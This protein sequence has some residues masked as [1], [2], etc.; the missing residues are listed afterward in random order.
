MDDARGIDTT[1]MWSVLNPSEIPFDCPPPPSIQAQPTVTKRMD[2]NLTFAAN[3][4]NL[5]G[6]KVPTSRGVILWLPARGINSVWRMGVVPVGTVS[7]DQLQYQIAT[8]TS[9]DTGFG[10]RLIPYYDASPTTPSDSLCFLTYVGELAIPYSHDGSNLA[11]PTG[12]NHKQFLVSPDFATTF[13]KARVIAGTLSIVS[14]TWVAS[15]VLAGGKVPLVGRLHAT[16]VLDVRSVMQTTDHATGQIVAFSSTA[17][18]DNS[19]PK[20]D[21]CTEVAVG[22]GVQFLVGPD[23]SPMLMPP[24]SD[25]CVHHNGHRHMLNV[26]SGFYD[27]STTPEDISTTPPGNFDGKH[28]M[29]SNHWVSPWSVTADTGIGTRAGFKGPTVNV[30]PPSF[31]NPAGSYDIEVLMN[32]GRFQ[33]STGPVEPGSSVGSIM[34]YGQ[35]VHVFAALAKDGSIQY[36]SYQ[37]VVISM[38][39]AGGGSDW[40]YDTLTFLFSAA[41]YQRGLVTNNMPRDLHLTTNPT[42]DFQTR[43]TSAMYIGSQIITGLQVFVFASTVSPGPLYLPKVYEFTMSVV[44][45]TQ[46]NMGELGPARIATYDGLGV[47]QAVT[48]NGVVHVQGVPFGNVAKFMDI[49]TYSRA[50]LCPGTVVQLGRLFD[51]PHTPF[52]RTWMRKDY[53]Q[54]VRTFE[55]SDETLASW[56]HVDSTAN[57]AKRRKM[58]KFD[59]RDVTHAD[60]PPF[61]NMTERLANMD[62][63]LMNTGK[64]KYAGNPLQ[65]QYGGTR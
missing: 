34:Y 41:K 46:N 32:V 51:S 27:V 57:D 10:L 49:N 16:T 56:I 50:E 52:R 5:Q 3:D 17:M 20:E 38:A 45:T 47:D 39:I 2:Y 26:T 55:L 21:D 54:F 25:S 22:K 62:K 23:M 35:A 37:E 6:E 28:Y 42:G 60:P 18:S 65:M 61:N 31:I 36:Y 33:T 43:I 7:Q 44:T 15:N 29:L 14:N 4:L 48:C 59:P 1:Y 19:V 11:G 13:S 12:L 30:Q 58:I 53:I 64:L 24:T 8:G 63:Y 40:G 9:I